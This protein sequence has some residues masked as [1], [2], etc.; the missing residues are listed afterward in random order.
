MANWAYIAT[1][2]LSLCGMMKSYFSVLSVSVGPQR[3]FMTPMN[4]TMT[5]YTKEERLESCTSAVDKYCRDNIGLDAG[6]SRVMVV[7]ESLSIISFKFS[8]PST[9]V[10]LPTASHIKTAPEN[11]MT[12]LLIAV[13]TRLES[14][15]KGRVEPERLHLLS[16]VVGSPDVNSHQYQCCARFR[17]PLRADELLMHLTEEACLSFEYGNKSQCG[18]I[19]RD[20]NR[21]M[22]LTSYPRRLIAR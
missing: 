9:I 12:R 18:H 6:S 2:L 14:M 20:E 3:L 11:P 19:L 5:T 13:S 17:L 7:A 8:R 4:F 21:G 16:R 22:S 10:L 15:T 1:I